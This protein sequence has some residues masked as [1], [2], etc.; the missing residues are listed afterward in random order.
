MEHEPQRTRLYEEHLALGGRMVEFAGWELPVQYDS[1]GALKEHQAVREAAGLFDIDHMGQIAVTG[2]DAAAFLNSLLT[3]DVDKL[4]L[5][6]A[7]YS[8]LPYADGGLVDDVLIYR[9]PEAW[10]VI[11]KRRQPREGPGVAAR[12]RRRTRCDDQ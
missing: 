11:V 2:P 9:L 3:T 7:G 8:F 12:S 4:E 5:W 1:T 10:W 6:Q